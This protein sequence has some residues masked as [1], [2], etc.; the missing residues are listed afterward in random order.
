MC[1]HTPLEL[2]LE[3][4]GQQRIRVQF[5]LLQCKAR[6]RVYSQWHTQSLAD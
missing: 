2:A 1:R 6:A 4:L 5:L 3:R